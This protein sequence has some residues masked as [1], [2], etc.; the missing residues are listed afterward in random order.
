MPDFKLSCKMQSSQT[1][2]GWRRYSVAGDSAE[3][4]AGAGEV[5]TDNMLGFTLKNSAKL[6]SIS[7]M[8]ITNCVND[9]ETRV[10]LRLFLPPEN[11]FFFKCPEYNCVK[12]E[13]MVAV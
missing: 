8:K 12:L 9:I 4:R 1:G 5:T 3:L 10:S 7:E 13:K 11:F 6:R 2:F